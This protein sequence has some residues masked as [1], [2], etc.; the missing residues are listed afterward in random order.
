MLE[1]FTNLTRKNQLEMVALQPINGD[2]KTENVILQSINGDLKKEKINK[3]QYT[4]LE[5]HNKLIL[6]KDDKIRNYVKYCENGIFKT[7]DKYGD[8]PFYRENLN[9][10][11]FHIKDC[12]IE[13]IMYFVKCKAYVKDIEKYNID[14]NYKNNNGFT[15]L[16]YVKDVDYLV[17]LLSLKF[18]VNHLANNGDTFLCPYV[19]NNMTT[20][21]EWYKLLKVLN[22]YDFNM[23]FNGF[24]L[25]DVACYYKLDVQIIILL[26]NKCNILTSSIW[27]Y[28]II[29]CYDLKSVT[30][31]ILNIKDVFFLNQM[32]DRY[33]LLYPTADNDM[34]LI[35][36]ILM[37]RYKNELINMI[38][39]V[40]DNGNNLLHIASKRH[41]DKVIRFIM[42][43]LEFGKSLMVKNKDGYGPKKLYFMN[44]VL[45]LLHEDI[46]L[47]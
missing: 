30:F 3:I 24:T 32:M 11:L 47:F 14:I 46:K 13:T 7:I 45:N 44:D 19:R 34:L 25:L 42:S 33:S 31:V 23:I 15:C 38:T 29:N 40:D 17:E 1:F 39:Y 2:Y 21:N 22:N 41:L 27:L 36:S 43:D 28:N 26:M 8:D 5:F 20:Y 6:L 9:D 35:I 12:P 10:I 16:W 37:H 4:I 18:N